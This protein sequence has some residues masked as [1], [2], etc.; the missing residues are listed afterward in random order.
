MGSRILINGSKWRGA[1][2]LADCATRASG[3]SEHREAYLIFSSERVE[4]CSAVLFQEEELA[5]R[6]A[7]QSWKQK[8]R[9]LSVY[10]LSKLGWTKNEE[11]E[12]N[13]ETSASSDDM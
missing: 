1:R 8:F 3:L 12:T 6:I 11:H 9:A 2:D 10:T 13:I 5:Q 4:F 7:L